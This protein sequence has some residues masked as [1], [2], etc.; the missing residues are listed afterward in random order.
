MDDVAQSRPNLLLASREVPQYHSNV[1]QYFEVWQSGGHTL[2]QY[3]SRQTILLL[4][5]PYIYHK[6]TSSVQNTY[7]SNIF[8]TLQFKYLLLFYIQT[9]RFKH[10]KSLDTPTYIPY[11]SYIYTG[12]RSYVVIEL[13]I[14]TRPFPIFADYLLT[15][16]RRQKRANTPETL[17]VKKFFIFS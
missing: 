4:R 7:I 11:I 10:G 2:P 17:Y 5:T 6:R 9:K 3:Y 14:F 16:G 15:P 1:T 8:C 13:N 12:N